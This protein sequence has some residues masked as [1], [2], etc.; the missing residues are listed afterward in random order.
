M[1]FFYYLEAFPW[2]FGTAM[3]VLAFVSMTIIGILL[4]RKCIH[5]SHLKAHHDVAGFVFANLGVLYSVLLAFTV[6]NVQARFE[7]I[8]DIAETESS[9]L[10]EIYYDVHV[11][12]EKERDQ[13]RASIKA[14]LQHVIKD[15]WPLLA[16][17]LPNA[18]ADRDFKEIWKSFY[19]LKPN[20]FIQQAWYQESIGKLNLLQNARLTR[21]L[22]G[23]ES[24]GKE[25]W[26][27]LILGGISLS[28]FVSLFGLENLFLHILMGIILAGTTAFLLYLIYTFDSAYSGVVKV[29]PDAFIRVLDSLPN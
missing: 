17:G 1:G 18:S 2:E 24:L 12:D 28:L 3:V 21:I 8:K 11:F 14:Y 6:V 20:G 26:T 23:K 4:M 16:K 5:S 19:S 22:G 13:I 27:F 9:I 25:M 7:K 15:E 29:T 10:A